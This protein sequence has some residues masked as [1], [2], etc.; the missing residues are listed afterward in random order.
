MNYEIKVKNKTLIRQSV[1]G[2]NIEPKNM[3][4][5][6]CNGETE[7]REF[8]SKLR[9]INTI[10]YTVRLINR[11][12][13]N[14]INITDTQTPETNKISDIKEIEKP[15]EN[16]STLDIVSLE[17]LGAKKLKEMFKDEIENIDSMTKKEI[18]E[19]LK[20]GVN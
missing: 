4:A 14:G 3:K 12:S 5:F 8:I 2:K 6:T 11:Q 15:V 1:L 19:N 13:V 18:L 20:T 9:K 7:F 16:N 10:T 17:K